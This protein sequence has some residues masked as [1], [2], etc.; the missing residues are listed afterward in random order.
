MNQATAYWARAVHLLALCSSLCL[1]QGLA[2][3]DTWEVSKVARTGSMPWSVTVSSDGHDLYVSLVGDRDRNN[4][5]RY[6]ADTLELQARSLFEGHA[7]E[8]ELIKN[9][10]RLLVTNSRVDLL[11]ELDADSL[12][13]LRRIRTDRVP[14][15]LDLSPDKQTAY[16][17]NYSAGTLSAIRLADGSATHVKTGRHA[18]GATVAPDG[19]EVYVMNF[20]AQSVSVVD[21]ANL[22]VMARIRTCARPRHGVVAGQ[23]LLVTCYGSRKVA[24]IDRTTRKVTRMLTVGAGPKTIALSKDGSMAVT[25]NER[26]NSI[27]IIDTSNWAVKTKPLSA[28]K[29]CGAA[30]SPDGL[31]IY[32]TARGS[33]Q[34]LKLVRTGLRPSSETFQQGSLGSTGQPV[35][36]RKIPR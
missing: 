9:D 10:T 5:W 11:M 7:V 18:R 14:K 8:S 23:N 15:D 33:N 36:T 35:R 25:A 12:Q 1:L 19:K 24:V 4:V 13:V 22:R 27:S 21:T 20:G 6:D 26:G 28:R 3:A 34:L 17:A 29:P 2:S 32:V 31:Q 16:I 30:I